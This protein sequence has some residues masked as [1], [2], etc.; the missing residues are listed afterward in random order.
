MDRRAVAAAAVLTAVLAIV[1]SLPGSVPVAAEA[2]PGAPPNV[3]LILSD[4]QHPA[5]LERMPYLSS[6]DD[7]L[8]F[9]N[10]ITNLALC[11]PARATLLTGLN[12][13]HHKIVSNEDAPKFDGR[14]TLA[15]WLQAAG[16]ETAYFG[17]YL[18]GFPWSQPADYIPEGWD[19]WVAF[20]GKQGYESF[21]ANIDG[22][23]RA[24]PGDEVY[25]EDFFADAAVDYIEGASGPYFAFVS[26]FAPHEPAT[27]PARHEYAEVAPYPP[28]PALDEQ[29]VNDKPF[30]VR[31]L[32][33]VD[34]AAMEAGLARQERALLGLDDAVRRIFAALEQSGGL[35]NTI[36]VYSTDNGLSWGEH[37]HVGKVCPY[38]ECVNVPFLVRGPG[39]E[40]GSTDALI[41]NVDFAP[42]IADYAGAEPQAPVDGRSLRPLLDG[43]KSRVRGGVLITRG[44]GGPRFRFLGVRTKNFKYVRY[45]FSREKELYDLRADPHELKSV[46]GKRAYEE[47][48]RKLRRQLRELRL[49]RSSCGPECVR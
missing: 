11:C 44:A 42:T 14:S 32:P 18:N 26:A 24:F 13:H 17:K 5:T 16:Y 27:P 43:E 47:T 30:W 49:E 6:R 7:W 48:E 9:D 21:N 20:A 35:E 31:E 15:V 46:D 1:T 37:R 39:I 12:S 45:R 34:P 3:I 22:E 23:V 41:G 38:E 8:R 29:N 28:R 33:R 25:S 10:A 2:A 36:V 19:R 40:P 4:D